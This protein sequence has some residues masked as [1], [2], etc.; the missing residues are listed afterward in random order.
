M[1]QSEEEVAIYKNQLIARALREK[2]LEATF[3][4]E[5]LEMTMLEVNVLL[6]EGENVVVSL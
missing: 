2:G 6:D 5:I 3:I 1:I 4:A